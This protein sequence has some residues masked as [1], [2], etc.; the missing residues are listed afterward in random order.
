MGTEESG[1]QTEEQFSDEDVAAAFGI[2]SEEPV[3]VVSEPAKEPVQD[4]QPQEK[5]EE[6][7]VTQQDAPPE[8]PVLTPEIIEALKILPGLERRLT[9]QV[10]RVAGNYGEV[11]RMLDSMQKDNTATPQGAADALEAWKDIKEEFGEEMAAK[12]AAG[13]DNRLK[14][15]PTISPEEVRK[16]VAETVGN[17]SGPDLSVL[18]ELHPGWEAY[19]TPNGD[20]SKAPPDYVEWFTSLRPAAKARLISSTDPYHVAEKLDEFFAWRDAKAADKQTESAHQAS[21]SRL[22][23]AVTP[24]GRSRGGPTTPSVED[25]FRQGSG[26]S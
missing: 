5:Q 1:N 16:I 21:T 7:K 20:M 8:N 12:F 22:E 15:V 26:E 23:A 11:K 18:D 4:V 13:V 9:Q 24:S 17:N 6:K 3:K 19:I 2:G 25:A 10:D 14:S